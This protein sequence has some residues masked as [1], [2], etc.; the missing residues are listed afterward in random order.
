MHARKAITGARRKSEA[1]RNRR[2]SLPIKTKVKRV[3]RDTLLSIEASGPEAKDAVA[4]AVRELDKAVSK[5][6]L[7][8]R[9]A[10]RRKSNLMRRLVAS[11]SRTE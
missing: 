4:G 6:V 7:H 2:R 10:A 11:A 3:V 8:R 1:E 5:G 9:T